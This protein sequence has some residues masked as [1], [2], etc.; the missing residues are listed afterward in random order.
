M[1]LVNGGID[2]FLAWEQRQVQH[3]EISQSVDFNFLLDSPGSAKHLAKQCESENAYCFLSPRALQQPH[4]FEDHDPGVLDDD[5]FSEIS[6]PVLRPCSLASS[7]KKEIFQ[8]HSEEGKSISFASGLPELSARLAAESL[9]LRHREAGM[10]DDA[11]I[12]E[13]PPRHHRKKKCLD[14]KTVTGSTTIHD[15]EQSA[16]LEALKN[17]ALSEK[18]IFQRFGK[19]QHISH[20][21]RAIL[22][23]GLIQRTGKGGV[24][25]PFRYHARQ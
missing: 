20:L 21:L 18:D 14:K 24:K 7:A 6:L 3:S 11:E 4:Y 12:A 1:T 13:A 16:I 25:D 9:K 5:F 17:E 8:K 10:F 23:E 22:R 15:K 2:E 19:S